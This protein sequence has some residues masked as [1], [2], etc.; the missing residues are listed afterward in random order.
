[1]VQPT[2]CGVAIWRFGQAAKQLHQSSE[3]R[4]FVE[5]NQWKLSIFQ[6]MKVKNGWYFVRSGF[7]WVFYVGIAYW[8]MLILDPLKVPK[9]CCVF[10]WLIHLCLW[11]EHSWTIDLQNL[12]V[13]INV[14][15]WNI[16]H[17]SEYTNIESK[18]YWHTGVSMLVFPHISFYA[19]LMCFMNH[20]GLS[21][22]FWQETSK[23]EAEL[24]MEI[25][26]WWVGRRS[27]KSFKAVWETSEL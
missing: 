24:T 9:D 4:S 19:W 15:V 16:C 18:T 17:C 6:V 20:E 23:H 8:D 12:I 5:W 14:F 25:K 7:L 27:F 13:L 11:E 26:A 1:M 3:K 21:L 10:S 22:W 2:S